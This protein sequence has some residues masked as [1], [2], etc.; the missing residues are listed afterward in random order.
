MYNHNN[1]SIWTIKIALGPLYKW[2]S[3]KVETIPEVVSVSVPGLDSI[4]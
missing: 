4:T 3:D 2:L 1:L